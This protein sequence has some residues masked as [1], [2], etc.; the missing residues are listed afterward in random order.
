MRTR[1]FT[2]V[3]MMAIAAGSV[4]TAGSTSALAASTQHA[5]SRVPRAPAA[6]LSAGAGVRQAL[7]AHAA[8][9]DGAAVGK[10]DHV[11]GNGT[12][13]SC[14]SAAVVSAVA[15]GGYIAFNCGR[16]PVTI[17][18]TATAKVSNTSRHVVLDGGGKVTLSGA[19]RR[20]ILYLDTCDRRQQITAPDCY[21]QQWPQLIVQNIALE[22]GNSPI[23]QTPGVDYGGG[24][25]GAI[26]D[27]GG[28]LK[29]VNTA[30]TGNLCFHEGPD[31]GGGA[32]RAL[33]QWQGRPVYLSD[34]TFAGNA[35]SNGGAISSIGVSWLIVNS[36]MTGN[37]AVGWGGNPAA[38]GTPGGGSG[39]AIYTDGDKYT[40]TIEDSTITGN[41]AREGGGGIFFVSDD[42][43]G[44]LSMRNCRLINNPSGVFWTRAYPGVYYNSA[45]L[46]RLLNSSTR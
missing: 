37:E 46:P 10:P 13:S 20:Q 45:G 31:L 28:Q 30:F 9:S 24:G 41:R 34:D 25:G 3:F 23:R 17:T 33:A 22:D 6:S 12:P 8:Q 19:G 38:R 2:G 15:S 35:C 18:M 42:H 5:E 16:K 36:V 29:V 4:L 21:D 27:L 7:P 32:I 11:I 40:V 26:F 1:G 14:T 39:G 44:T 43:T